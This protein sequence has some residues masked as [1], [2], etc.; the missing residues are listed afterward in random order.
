M[1]VYCDHVDIRR[2][3]SIPSTCA[4]Y[5][6]ALVTCRI[7]STACSCRSSSVLLGTDALIL[8]QVPAHA[9]R[10][11]IGTHPLQTH[12]HGGH[13]ICG[14]A[15]VILHVNKYLGIRMQSYRLSRYSARKGT[16]A[17]R[18]LDRGYHMRATNAC[19]VM[20][21]AGATCGVAFASFKCSPRLP[22]NLPTKHGCTHHPHC[23]TLSFVT[24]WP[25]HPH[26]VLVCKW[27]MWQAGLTCRYPDCSGDCVHH[28]AHQCTVQ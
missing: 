19:P 26:L 2:L 23:K 10:A 22:T 24:A 9:F 4:L 16:V 8:G 25:R 3:C 14:L 20:G 21:K 13:A 28:P 1:H 15:Y 6:V 7:L 12:A 17:V 5:A 18:G 11:V 27:H